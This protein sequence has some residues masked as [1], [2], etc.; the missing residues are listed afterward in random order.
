MRRAVCHR[1]EAKRSA[2]FEGVDTTTPSN[3]ESNGG[4]ELALASDGPMRLGFGELHR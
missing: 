4:A 1:S 3:V 2:T